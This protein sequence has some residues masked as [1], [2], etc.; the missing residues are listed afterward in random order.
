MNKMLI[1]AE[2]IFFINQTQLKKLFAIK[3]EIEK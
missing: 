1:N 2:I 3:K